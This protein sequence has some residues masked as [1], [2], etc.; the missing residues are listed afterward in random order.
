MP[1]T[2]AIA[3][4][5]DQFVKS[6][7][8]KS[9]PKL[10][11][12]D[13]LDSFVT[14]FKASK[15]N[16]TDLRT[17]TLD[18][19][20]SPELPPTTAQP[21][22]PF[23]GNP[24]TPKRTAPGPK[25]LDVAGASPRNLV[26][27]DLNAPPVLTQEE[28]ARVGSIS[29]QPD[30]TLPGPHGTPI[31]LTASDID[32]MG[33]T[34]LPGLNPDATL[35]GN[36]PIVDPNRGLVAPQNLL[37]EKGQQEHPILT[38]LGQLGEGLTTPANLAILASSAGLGELPAWARTGLSAYFAEQ[39]A[40]G[41]T[42]NAIEGW[43]AYK[44]G[45]NRE[46][47][48]LWTLAAGNTVLG[49][50][51]G[52]HTIRESGVL[53]DADYDSA[54]PRGTVPEGTVSAPLAKDAAVS[55]AQRIMPEVEANA[56][57]RRG[58]PAV[59]QAVAAQR[60]AAINAPVNLPKLPETTEPTPILRGPMQGP[61]P[62]PLTTEA[63]QVRE[64]RANRPQSEQPLQVTDRRRVGAGGERLIP[65][66]SETLKA[67][68]DAL[69]K[70]TNSVVYFPKGTETIPT[71]PEDANVTIVKGNKPGAGTYYHDD[72]VT[73]ADIRKAVKNG[74]YG[75]LL[76]YVQPKGE[77]ASGQPA[78]LVARDARGVELKA[79]LVD[80]SDASI[81]SKQAAILA[82]Q[83]PG[84]EIKLETA[85]QTISSRKAPTSNQ[86]P[87]GPPR[88]PPGG[89]RMAVLSRRA[90]DIEARAARGELIPVSDIQQLHA[91]ADSLEFGGE[92]GNPIRESATGAG[93]AQEG[94]ALTQ[95]TRSTAEGGTRAEVPENSPGS[96]HEI[97]RT[98]GAETAGSAATSANTETVSD[99]GADTTSKHLEVGDSVKITG[100]HRLSG[101]TAEVTKVEDAGVFVR[102]GDGPIK[103]IKNGEFEKAPD[104]L[105]EFIRDFRP[106]TS[107]TTVPESGFQ[108]EA[109]RDLLK[110]SDRPELGTRYSG[111]SP[112]ALKKLLPLAAQERIDAEVQA[113]QRARSLQGKLY[114]LDSQGAA[115]RIRAKNVLQEAPGSHQDLEAIYHHLEDSDEP[116]TD[117]QRKILDGY[118]RPILSEGE[119]INRKLGSGEA[120][121]YVHRIPVGKG[122][123]LDRIVEGEGELGSGRGLSKSSSSLK[124]RT[125]MV[126]EDETGNRRVVS[127]KDGKV[128][129]WDDGKPEDLGRIRG[130][131]V[132]GVKSKGAVLDRELAP[133]RDELAKLETERRTLT[134]TKGREA[135]SARRLENI[136]IRAA[137]IREALQDAYRTNEGK[138]LS[139]DD[140]R[141]KVFVD[142]NGKEWRI[143]QATTREIEANTNVRYYKNALA[144]SLMNYLSLRRAERSYDFLEAYKNSPDFRQA[145]AKV[146]GGRV[147]AGWRTT[148]L[149]QFHGYAF[150]PH[151]AEVLDWYSKRLQAEGPGIYQKIGNFLRT[152]IFFNPLIHT[153]NI[154]V[155]WI[156]EKGLTGV[157]PQNWGRILRTGS[158]AID[159]VIHQNADFL[160]ALDHGAPLQSARFGNADATR[161]LVERMG[162]ELEANPTAA[163]RVAKALGYVGPG[164]LI[165]AVYDFS[166]KVTWISNDIAMLQAAYEHMD[167]TGASFK[168]AISDVSK[169]IPD[170][171]L[172]T[173]IFNSPTLAKLMSN[174]NLT[175]FG[176]YHY[177]ALR[178]YGEML[179]GMISENVPPGEQLKSLDRLAMLGLFTFVAY[180]ALDQL[181]KGLTG[182]KT[183]QFRRAGASTFIY[184]LVQLAK[185][186][187]SPA[188]VLQS[189]ATPA[190]HTKAAIE[191]AANRDAFSG[192]HIVDWN[193]DRKTIAKQLMRFAGQ[194][195]APVNVGSQVAEGKRTLGQQVA[196]LF[197]IRTKVPTPAEALARKYAA[198]AAGS[199][200]PDPDTVERSY[201]RRQMED[202]LRQKKLGAT[203]IAK[204]RASGAITAQD[205]KTIVQRAARTPLQ[206]AFR[207]LTAEQ[208]LRVWAKAGPEEQ[209]QVRPM[210]ANK[211]N[212]LSTVPA[213]RRE[214][215]RQQ[216]MDAL[217]SPTRASTV[218]RT[219]PGMVGSM[220]L[221]P[222]RLQTNP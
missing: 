183:A 104:E 200:A 119:R 185:G 30:V 41:A 113:N 215:V 181:A 214:E 35:Q 157:G 111:L 43:K 10:T 219:P 12:D 25:V 74:T 155:H 149:P 108:T 166:G 145:A 65:E 64:D 123:L 4:E 97:A 121:N 17:P 153:P 188:E 131:E 115:D 112:A 124:R 116:L 168:E 63:D 177:G 76:G 61:Q 136:D 109:L 176:A 195:I 102:Q 54:V 57:A 77:A 120:E 171:R 202:A 175:M 78:T 182:D 187:K 143:G 169:H 16:A 144:S 178:S 196:G 90:A 47:Q 73:P 62:N 45:D 24:F 184:N 199:S 69:D 32:S 130:L 68:T 95:P 211:L 158:R 150:D 49:A 106:T 220:P 37:G 173:R 134:A 117:A 92:H 126:L 44:R 13:D 28:Q 100:E 174:P 107:H 125:M 192:R 194:N 94:S 51:A 36:A 110:E 50:A 205:E 132:Q 59:D 218:P 9:A 161:L 70:G 23:P 129:A 53:P 210:L 148:D 22:T 85:E 89:M 212:R 80:S 160:D 114:D 162:R 127:I 217:H 55:R 75:D 7:Q 203:D 204:A 93:S 5:L 33:K 165:R 15:G 201:L 56:A 216:I 91:A 180:P 82:K 67:Q 128:T 14:K 1:P 186:D 154:G 3:D 96:Q 189:V 72:S 27:G 133:L 29:A 206:N 164:K 71:P 193:A 208:A 88:T 159:A 207:T 190:V 140:L 66:T 60:D 6:Y 48:R 40:E 8:S 84:S 79:A 138:L 135:V 87:M 52:A 163:G 152:S 156:A 31:R 86:I 118:I 83:F 18:E 209:D 99:V 167:R 122:N 105:D 42:G 19:L 26:G 142:K 58:L 137:E 151:T 172:P 147:P 146:S 20:S 38:G 103:F 213:A 191:L 81:V 198:E 170:Y 39:M 2:A 222:P 221:S 11:P 141:G 179:K 101:Q 46:A 21:D 98:S 139:E 34:I 197:G